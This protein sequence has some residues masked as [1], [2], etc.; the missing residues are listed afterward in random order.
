MAS[1]QGFSQPLAG[2]VS[3]QSRSAG[4]TSETVRAGAADWSAMA[5][6][7]GSRSAAATRAAANIL[8]G[9]LNDALLVVK[10]MGAFSRSV[11]TR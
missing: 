1:C 6:R 8:G 3:G 4:V 5:L 11:P 7:R 10:G 9:F 2:T